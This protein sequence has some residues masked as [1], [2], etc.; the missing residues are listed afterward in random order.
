M[1]DSS[2][3]DAAVIGPT[4]SSG[5]K[6]SQHAILLNPFTSAKRVV[7]FIMQSTD[8]CGC[9]VGEPESPE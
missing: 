3:I 5:S 1:V 6:F 9:N 8:H 2:L 4:V 7:N